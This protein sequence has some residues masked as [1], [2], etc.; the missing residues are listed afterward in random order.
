MR[1]LHGRNYISDCMEV[2]YK[3]YQRETVEIVWEVYESSKET[4]PCT[5]LG[6][7][8]FSP[9]RAWLGALGG[10]CKDDMRSS[11]ELYPLPHGGCGCMR[12]FG[13]AGSMSGPSL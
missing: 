9:L 12:G 8:P 6:K 4:D 11:Q 7:T 13:I 3:L 10:I 1:N 5:C 2:T